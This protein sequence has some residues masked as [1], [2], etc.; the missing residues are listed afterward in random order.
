MM[1]MTIMITTPIMRRRIPRAPT[2]RVCRSQYGKTYMVSEP[3]KHTDTDTHR[4]RHRHTQTHTDTD[5]HTYT[6]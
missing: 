6:P 4:H 3:R 1:E 5:T 2:M